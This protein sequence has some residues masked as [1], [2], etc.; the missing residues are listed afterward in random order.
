MNCNYLLV[1]L[2]VR[3]MDLSYIVHI[4]MYFLHKFIF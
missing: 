1:L 3:L 4:P 2:T